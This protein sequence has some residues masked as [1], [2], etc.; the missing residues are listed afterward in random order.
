MPNKITRRPKILHDDS[1]ERIFTI[2]D[3]CTMYN[4]SPPTL[5]KWQREGHFPQR[6]TFQ[7]GRVGWRI[8]IVEAFLK[9]RMKNV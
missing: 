9:Q 4:I 5:Y 2:T 6:E 3:I 1:G 7:S 8:S